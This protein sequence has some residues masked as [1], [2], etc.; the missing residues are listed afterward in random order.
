[1]IY[2]FLSTITYNTL[3]GKQKSPLLQIINSNDLP[4]KGRPPEE[5]NFRDELRVPNFFPVVA[6]IQGGKQEIVGRFN[7]ESL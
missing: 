6:I 4:V 1:M 5:V 7:I 3:V 2:V